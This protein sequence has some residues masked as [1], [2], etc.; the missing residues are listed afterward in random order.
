M[1]HAAG[2]QLGVVVNKVNNQD[3]DAVYSLMKSEDLDILGSI[4]FDEK[5]ASGTTD[6]N[7]NIV[8][9]AVKQFYFRLNLPQENS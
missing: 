9:E 5:L 2:G 4:P 3:L 1:K 7:S 8:K 6:W